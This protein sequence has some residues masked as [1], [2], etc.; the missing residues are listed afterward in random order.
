MMFPSCGYSDLTY[1]LNPIS[2]PQLLWIS[3]S[4]EWNYLDIRAVNT[5]M[6]KKTTK[7]N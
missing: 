2:C 4:I 6:Q 5:N 3:E 1:M 7:P